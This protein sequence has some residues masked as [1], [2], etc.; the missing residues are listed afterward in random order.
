[1]RLKIQK[2]VKYL[3]KAKAANLNVL[4]KALELILKRKLKKIFGLDTVKKNETLVGIE[5][6]S[7]STET[8]NFFI[9][10]PDIRNQIR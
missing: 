5:E 1:M 10:K 2:E 4:V 6:M 8:K 7:Q 3:L 9:I